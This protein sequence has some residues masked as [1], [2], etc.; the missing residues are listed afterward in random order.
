MEKIKRSEERNRNVSRKLKE[1]I[2]VMSS[3]NNLVY[4]QYTKMLI[5]YIYGHEILGTWQL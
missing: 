2:K 1:D 5:L 4:I 3:N